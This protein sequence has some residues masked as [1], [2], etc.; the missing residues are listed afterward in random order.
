VVFV[1]QA[2]QTAWQL[3]YQANKLASLSNQRLSNEP[4]VQRIRKV[5][6]TIRPLIGNDDGASIPHDN[7]KRIHKLTG[8]TID[9]ITIKG[10]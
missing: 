1:P 7:V 9:A 8:E 4:L 3:L 10:N 5:L 2:L 6:K